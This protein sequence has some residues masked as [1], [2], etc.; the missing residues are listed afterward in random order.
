MSDDSNE[1]TVDARDSFRINHDV[2][3]EH[4]MV[5]AYAAQHH[6]VHT[7][8]PP[9]QE[10]NLLAQLQAINKNNQQALHVLSENNRLLGDYLQA[11][12]EKIDLIAQHIAFHNSPEAT[13][14]HKNK[15]E[16]EEKKDTHKTT[17]INLGENGLSFFSNRA[18]YQ[19]NYL[20]LRVIFLPS[21]TTITT[22]AKVVRCEPHGEK[23][24]VA[25]Q[26]YRL[27]ETSRQDIAREILQSQIT[28]RHNRC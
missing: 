15:E 2:L 21:Y 10:T 8:L 27:A 18:L 17:R 6:D 24:R 19:G 4:K 9:T 7:E 16:K 1:H 12:S 22:F 13:P 5:E 11:M 28:R 3:F 14:S 25:I 26:F 23:Y 20:V